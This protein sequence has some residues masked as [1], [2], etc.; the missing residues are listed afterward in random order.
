MAWISDRLG[1]R[2]TNDMAERL[3]GNL[4]RLKSERA[5]LCDRDT[6]QRWLRELRPEHRTQVF[7][8]RPWGTVVAV[9]DRNESVQVF[10]SDGDTT[11]FAAA[12][13][14]PDG[15]HLT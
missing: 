5:E 8:H 10:L 4:L 1:F 15:Q 13:G 7:V 2:E 12:P 14:S 6:V 11:W 3:S 9:A